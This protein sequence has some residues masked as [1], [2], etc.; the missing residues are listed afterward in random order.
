MHQLADNT[1][2][3]SGTLTRKPFVNE[4]GNFAAGNLAIGENGKRAWI[5]LVAFNGTSARLAAADEGTFLRCIARIESSKRQDGKGWELRF[6]VESWL[7][8]DPTEE[9]AA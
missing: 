1:L 8:A 3:V 4:R 5:S 9:E 6:V 7:D 2:I